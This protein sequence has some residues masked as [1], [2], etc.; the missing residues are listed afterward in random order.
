MIYHL[1]YAFRD[2]VS[3]FNVFRYLT[4][5]TALATLTA[6]LL[7]LILGP[8][9]I[10]RLQQL[11]VEQVTRE[12]GP[13]H[14]A[15]KTGTPTMGGLLIV[16]AVVVPTL[17]WAEPTNMFIWIATLSCLAALE[18]I[19]GLFGYGLGGSFS[20]ADAMGKLTILPAAFWAG[21]WMLMSIGAMGIGLWSIVKRRRGATAAP[22]LPKT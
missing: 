10:R 11:Q 1:L 22:G 14:H 2:E 5:R 3:A 21:S 17:L 12:E 7:S 20:D 4:L 15:V 9:V 6:L 19:K 13:S 18:D 8:F 16:T